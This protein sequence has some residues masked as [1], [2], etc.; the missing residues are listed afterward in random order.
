MI[1]EDAIRQRWEAVGC[2]CDERG[3]RGAVAGRPFTIRFIDN[4]KSKQAR[5][6]TV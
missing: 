6:P 3:R 5:N 2:N 4:R 1:D